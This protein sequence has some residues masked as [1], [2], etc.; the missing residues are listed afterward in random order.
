LRRAA[1]VVVERLDRLFQV[2]AHSPPRT[3]PPALLIVGAPR[4][5]TTLFYQTVASHRNTVFINNLLERLPLSG[6]RLARWVRL[7][8]WKPPLSTESYYGETPGLAGP[9]EA[10]PFWD[11]VFPRGLHHAVE[12]EEADPE[13]MAWFRSTVGALVEMTGR[14]F[15]SKNTWNSVRIPA[16][17][18]ALP[19]AVFILVE[20]DPLYTAQSLLRGRRERFGEA[21]GPWSILPREMVA[22]SDL[23]PVEYVANQIGYTYRAIARAREQLGS[24]RFFTVP[25]EDFC[26]DPAGTLE[27]LDAFCKMRGIELTR[28][29][30]S[31]PRPLRASAKIELRAEEV[32]RL[33]AVFEGFR[34]DLVSGRNTS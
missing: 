16:L 9:S 1:K 19:R 17:H 4:S 5:G 32:S 18:R 31:D 15:L 8:L 20:R 29:G 33:R 24:D 3:E 2:P 6:V 10:G 25:Y 26:K 13:R 14:P 27:R 11:H 23:P 34:G 30:G 21:P 7:D 22:M 28:T 12:L